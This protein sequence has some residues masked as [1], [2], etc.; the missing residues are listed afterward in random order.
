[1]VLE[2]VDEY[3]QPLTREHVQKVR[4]WYVAL[5]ERWTKGF[6]I[7]MLQ[8]GTPCMCV[9]G[10]LTKFIYDQNPHQMWEQQTLKVAIDDFATRGELQVESDLGKGYPR[11]MGRIVDYNDSEDIQFAD[12]I[13]LLDKVINSFDGETVSAS[14]PEV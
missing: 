1:M 5:P 3:T 8:D 10:A 13:A 2:I 4:E 9:G 6:S 14:A 12:I 11:A 7:K